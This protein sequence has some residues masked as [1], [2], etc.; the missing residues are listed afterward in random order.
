MKVE[1]VGVL[2]DR[3]GRHHG[4]ALGPEAI[5]Y[6]F[7]RHE[8]RDVRMLFSHQVH[9]WRTVPTE[10]TFENA[11]G[12]RYFNQAKTAYLRL[13]EEVREIFQDGHLPIVLGGDH[14]ISM[15]SIAA[16]HHRIAQEG[17]KLAVL[18]VDAHA[19]VNSPES[20]PSGNL[21]GMPL[22]ALVGRDAGQPPADPDDP[23]ALRRAQW[24]TLL[25]EVIR[26]DFLAPECVAYLGLRDVDLPEAKYIARKMPGSLPI[27][28]EGIDQFGLSP[29]FP[30][31]ERWFESIGA[32][33]LWVSFDVDVLDPVMAPGTGTT[34]RG[35][36]TYREAH[37]LAEWLH[38]AFR[39][40]LAGID[41]VELNPM[42]DASSTTVRVVV[43]WMSSLFGKKI[44]P[45]GPHVTPDA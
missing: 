23:R 37:L 15:G 9:R 20:S 27:T 28:M 1:I 26:N 22:G 19:D 5:R 34:V 24:N 32:T 31:I 43:E 10:P 38:R 39:T 11:R 44:L 40:R 18:W 12:L 36:L 7:E 2:F 41:V 13:Y 4:S 29:F 33:H 16:A 25:N 42:L 21:H 45:W 6:A 17:G 3:C 35:G 14:S 8:R 30:K